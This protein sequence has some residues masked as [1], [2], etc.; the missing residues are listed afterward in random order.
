MDS[1]FLLLGGSYGGLAGISDNNVAD[2][3]G[4]KKRKRNGARLK[5]WEN[6]PQITCQ[7]SDRKFAKLDAEIRILCRKS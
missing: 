7:F 5:A 2:I 4:E 1:F 6:A 3:Y